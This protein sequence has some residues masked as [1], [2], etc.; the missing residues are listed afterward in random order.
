MNKIRILTA[1]AALALFTPVA[2]LQ[3]Q[4][5]EG[6]DSR[7]EAEQTEVRR[8]RRGCGGCCQ[9]E[10]QE[11]GGKA[12]QERKQQ[13]GGEA[14]RQR[15]GERGAMRR[16]GRG[17][18]RGGG[19]CAMELQGTTKAEVKKEYLAR[20]Q[21]TVEKELYA[22]DYY[23]AAANALPGVR[24]F[25]NLTTAEQR[26]ADAI[27]S[28]IR[29]LGGTASTTPTIKVVT[30]KTVAEADAECRKI[31]LMVIDIYKGL[32]KD[33]PDSKVTRVLKRIQSSNYRHLAAVGG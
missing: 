23:K 5:P 29:Y 33:S 24:R 2:L 16:G 26:H 11:R 9:A 7:A 27:V 18:Q 6:D 4:E 32:I 28:A 3:A 25:A 17:A 22:R 14:R 8:G 20:L 12:R 1:V 13:R 19:C 21:S 15:G 31:E 30:P 10:R